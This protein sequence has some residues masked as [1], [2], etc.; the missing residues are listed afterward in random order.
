MPKVSVVM[1]LY[2]TPFEYLSKTVQSILD[3]TFSD[4]ELIIIDDSTEVDCSNFFKSFNDERIKHIRPEKNYGPGNARN[5]GMKMAQGEYVAIVD[6]DDVYAKNRFEKQVDFLDSNPDISIVGGAFKYSNNG[7]VPPVIE[8]SDDINVFLLFNAPM[9][10]PLAMLRKNVFLEQN[11]FYPDRPQFGE[12]YELWLD[13]M[14]AGLKMSNLKDILMTYTRRPGQLTKAKSDFQIESL[15]GIYKKTLLRFG[16]NPTDEDINLHHSIYSQKY[17]DVTVEQVQTWFNKIIE[18]NQE[19]NL[20]NE[21]AINKYLS[22]S[23][24]QLQKFKNRLFKIKIG[25]YNLCMSKNLKIYLEK[26]D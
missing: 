12:D 24:L 13:A 14:F 16:L 8:N 23:L 10:N 21:K 25:Q 26:R 19:T 20:F 15:K 17:D 11:L 2:N 7:K 1:A 18:K 22:N 9:P 3:Q 4:F 6:S 5:E